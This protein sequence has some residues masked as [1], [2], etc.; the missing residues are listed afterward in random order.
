MTDEKQNLIG[1]FTTDAELRV[2]VWDA[3]L[4]QMTGVSADGVRGRSITEVIPNLETRGLLTRFWRVLE[5]GT[6]EMLAP[7]FHRFLI[8]CPPRDESEHFAEMRQ[9]VTIAPL[10]E[11]ENIRGLIVTIEDVTA[12]VEREIELTDQLKD[13][14]AAVRLEAAKALSEETENLSEETATPIIAALDDKNWRVRRELAAGLSRRA[15]PDAIAALLRAMQEKHLD[16]AVLNSALKVLQATS[17][18]TTE[19]LI[20][21]LEGADDDLRMQAALTLGE[22]RDAQAVPALLRTLEDENVNV[23]FHAIEALGKLKAPEAVEKLLEI[24]ENRDF[25]LSFAALEALRGIRDER[26]AAQV[27]PLLADDALREAAIETL[28]AV[29]GE[30]TVAPLV[31]LLNEDAGAA[32]PVAHA[33]DRLATLS[34]D[35]S[36]VIERA[37]DSINEN[38]KLNLLEALNGANAADET[39]L[40]RLGGWFAD[41]RISE[42]LADLLENENLR[43]E[44][45]RALVRHGASAVDLLIERLDSGEDEARPAIARTLGQ[46]GDP[47]AFEALADLLINGDRRMRQAATEALKALAHP[48]TVELLCDLLNHAPTNV[49]EAVIRVV[50]YFGAKGCED[51]IFEFCQEIDEPLRRA[52]IEQLPHIADKRSVPTLIEALKHESSRVRETAAKAL[53]QVKSDDSI[54]ALREALADADSWT[55][56][57]AVR[58]LGT[59]GDTASGER[60]S[61][62]A[63]TDAAEHVRA[64]AREVLSGLQI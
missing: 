35:E 4:E 1:I 12:R 6:V 19:P 10:T 37:Q 55:R 16:F 18:R 21:F 58:A 59:L 31:D 2:Q 23:R 42:K 64:A 11:D 63:D 14:D 36:A 53:A 41:S 40:V 5:D 44:A 22:Q 15:A 52:A 46:I 47:R 30:E 13:G 20:E 29:G 7:A 57:F 43:D 28:G 27:L 32:L 51:K 48:Q 34:E 61:E 60:I 8:P 25:F 33:L 26:I 17:V 3:A 9:R 54:G 45:A 24:V 62:M 49:R 39:S 50:G 38:G 56:Y